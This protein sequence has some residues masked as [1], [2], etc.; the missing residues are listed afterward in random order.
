LAAL[1]DQL[2]SYW[3][4]ALNSYAEVVSEDTHD[5]DEREGNP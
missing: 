5:T 4:Q 1:R 2:D 3:R